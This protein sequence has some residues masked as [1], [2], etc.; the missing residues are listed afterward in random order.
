MSRS[1]VKHTGRLYGGEPE[2]QN[3][4]VRTEEGRGIRVALLS[5]EP[6]S[7]TAMD[8]AELE[9]RVLAQQA[10]DGT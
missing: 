10:G 2:L 3:I 4:P 9:L 1:P 8:Y 7:V 5:A 6:P